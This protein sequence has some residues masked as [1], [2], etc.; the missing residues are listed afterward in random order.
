M[1]CEEDSS[2][3]VITVSTRS[4]QLL[5]LQHRRQQEVAESRGNSFPPGVSPRHQERVADDVA[6]SA[7][8][9]SCHNS[10][11]LTQN[12]VWLVA[13]SQGAAS[14]LSL[15]STVQL[16]A[17][18]ELWPP[19]PRL[20]AAS[21]ETVGDL[22][23]RGDSPELGSAA[24]S[25]PPSPSPSRC[26]GDDSRDPPSDVSW[27]AAEAS[28][29]SQ[30]EEKSDPRGAAAAAPVAKTEFSD[31]FSLPAAA[32]E[33]PLPHRHHHHH[34]GAVVSHDTRVEEEERRKRKQQQRADWER[35]CREG[36][37]SDLTL[38][39]LVVRHERA[40][41]SAEEE[42]QA[43]AAVRAG[44]AGV[45]TRHQ[46][47]A[48]AALTMPTLFEVHYR[49]P[50]KVIAAVGTISQF[51]TRAG[52][53]LPPMASDSCE[54]F[55]VFVAVM[56][57]S[58]RFAGN[59]RLFWNRVALNYFVY[60][61]AWLHQL[62]SPMWSAAG[63]VRPTVADVDK[64]LGL[65]TIFPVKLGSFIPVFYHER[66]RVRQLLEKICEETRHGFVS[67]ETTG[68]GV[69]G[70][71]VVSGDYA[72]SVVALFHGEAPAKPDS[73]DGSEK[74]KECEDRKSVV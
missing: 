48:R 46:F 6:K 17:V 26:S 38:E 21:G 58:L 60:L 68:G 53:Q 13:A 59:M 33:L 32:D 15:A 11:H 71:V 8:S 51:C 39:D 28:A 73:A 16:P 64:C 74:N 41:G 54:T 40:L 7:S 50:N 37:L 43:L 70:Y 35:R 10:S 18:R 55:S 57:A 61:S 27:R 4:S 34:H 67:S 5:A 45:V 36:T 69:C 42:K 1:F 30:S 72:F 44:A 2:P 63:K 24:S 62:S 47:A 25:S 65:S 49:I 56:I 12:P 66:A 31:G 29:A 3:P 9:Q 14:Q 23:N 52:P 20:T 19:R 22:L